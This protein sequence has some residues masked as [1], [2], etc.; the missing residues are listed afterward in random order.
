[1]KRSVWAGLIR[2]YIWFQLLSF[3]LSQHLP[4]NIDRRLFRLSIF[5]RNSNV[6]FLFFIPISRTLSMLLK[7][8]CHFPLTLEKGACTIRNFWISFNFFFHSLSIVHS[9][10]CPSNSFMYCSFWSRHIQP[11]SLRNLLALLS[12]S[13]P[14]FCTSVPF[15]FSLNIVYHYLL[16]VRIVASN[17][18]VVIVWTFLCCFNNKTCTCPT[19]MQYC[20]G[21]NS[22][23]IHWT[24]FSGLEYYKFFKWTVVYR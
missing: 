13:F 17:S 4:L 15:H 19:K 21:R 10:F 9:S 14:Y 7:C 24:L 1:M 8:V 6:K 2:L 20:V 12:K 23:F 11:T 22:Y 18:I 5:S 16:F 3:W